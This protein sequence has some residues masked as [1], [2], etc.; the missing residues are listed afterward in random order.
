[1]RLAVVSWL[2]FVA[3]VASGAAQTTTGAGT[4]Q[5]TLQAGSSA[6]NIGTLQD[7]VRVCSTNSSEATFPGA[8]GVCAGYISGVLDYH[9]ADTDWVGGRHNRQVCMPRRTADA[10]GDATISRE[11]GSVEPAIQ[12]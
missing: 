5:P 8:I 1:M 9:L 7:L 2:A 6:Y 10:D 4:P 11:L 12:Q 3:S